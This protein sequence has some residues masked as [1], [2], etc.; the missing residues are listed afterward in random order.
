MSAHD[1][2]RCGHCDDVIGV[3]EPIVVVHDGVPVRTS[4]AASELEQLSD[5]PSFHA[6]CFASAPPGGAGDR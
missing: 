3:Y 4:R 5:K 2:L 1:E 6:A